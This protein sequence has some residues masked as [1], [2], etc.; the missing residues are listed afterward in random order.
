ME[1]VVYYQ[2]AFGLL[3]SALLALTALRLKSLD[4]SGACAVFIIM[5]LH[6]SFGIRFGALY[7][8]Y[9]LTSSL[10]IHIEEED[11]R[12]V[13]ADLR[14]ESPRNWIEV[15]LNSAIAIVLVVLLWKMGGW[16][17]HCL[18][19]KQSSLITSL[20]GGL[21][22]HYSCC[23]SNKWSS[24]IGMLSPDRPILI[25]TLKQ[26]ERGTNGGVTKEG[27]IAAMAAGYGIGITFAFAGL[28]TAKCT[29]DVGLKQIWV[30]PFCI[31]A[32]LCGSLTR[33]LLGAAFQFSGF[34][35]VSERVVA[36]PA[37]AVT[38]ISGLNILGN[39]TVT[40]LSIL[41]TTLLTSFASLFIF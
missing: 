14:R 36:I 21:L 24:E 41:L 23:C 29:V 1:K 4:K 17:D 34:C 6:M 16:K 37:P 39:D 35:R 9:F 32:G 30:V 22:G 10:V 27:V 31:G 33:S 13:V 28:L 11:N 5:A 26:V 15:L 2:P 12:T 40:F 3:V 20:M 18:D 7:L 25:T 8:F 19:S 38:K